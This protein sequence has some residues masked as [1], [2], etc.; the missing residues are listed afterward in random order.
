M[1]VVLINPPYPAEERYG[2][3]AAAGSSL[4]AYGLL[5]MAA[6]LEKNGHT[7]C[8]IDAPAR[9]FDLAGTI[10]R[11]LTFS[12]RLVGLTA[13]TPAIHRAHHVALRCRELL[14]AAVTVIGGPHISAC[15]EKTMTDYPAFDVGVIGEG[16]MTLAALTDNAGNAAGIS[17][18]IHRG[19]DGRLVREPPRE[20]IPNLDS[21]PVPAWHLLDGFPHAY[22]PALFK[23]RRL[24]AASIITSRGCPN[25]CIFCDTSVFR[26]TVRRHSVDYLLDMLR[27]LHGRYGVREIS[28]EDDTF[29]LK[30]SYVLEL[31]RRLTASKLRISW[32][33][34]ARVNLVDAELLRAMRRAGCWQVS[35]GIESG[36]QRILDFIRK[37]TTVEQASRAV[38]LSRQAGLEVKGFFIIGF[39]TETAESL[40]ATE[41]FI[42][43][44]PLSDVSVFKLTPLPGSQVYKMAADYGCFDDNTTRMNLLETVFVPNGLSEK[45]LDAVQGRIVR[46]FYLSPGTV[47]RYALKVLRRPRIFPLLMRLFTR[48]FFSR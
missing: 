30:R 43:R 17:G 48:Q 15:P 13:V 35:Y 42:R 31:C 4:P 16:E 3:F 41:R 38:R 29:T 44:E 19:P 36:D 28:F 22:R 33:V 7:V 12:P 37:Q 27:R 39:P 24:P 18:T 23:Y 20:V 9:D 32:T 25:Q 8:I 5:T 47:F 46:R 6:V 45:T 11:V 2:K 40:A 34:N 14:P 10:E 26:S 21:L 1:R